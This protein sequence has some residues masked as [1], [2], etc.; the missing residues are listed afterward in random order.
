MS[1][2]K[3][4]TTLPSEGPGEPK[5]PE[6]KEGQTPQDDKFSSTTKSA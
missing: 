2:S 6:K 4:T 1:D 5:K 3:K